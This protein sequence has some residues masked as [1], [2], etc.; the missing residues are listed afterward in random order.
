MAHGP[1][2]RDA[3]RPAAPFVGRQR[4]RAELS[5]ALAGALTGDGSLLLL[6]GES[7]IGKTRLAREV[8]DEA[9]ARGA[10]VLWGAAWDAGGAPAFWP[11]MQAIR[12]LLVATDED[13]LRS[14]L[15]PGAAYV[16]QIVGDVRERVPGLAPAPALDSD[17]ARFTAFDATATF[18]RAAAARRP[19]LVVLDDLH[20]AD[21]PSVVLL[22]FLAR[23]LH[24]A[25]ILLLGTY[26]EREA[27]GEVGEALAA[28]RPAGRTLALRGLE[29]DDVAVLVAAQAEGPA[30]DRL[31]RRVHA[32]TEGN[33]LFVDEVTRLLAAEGGLEA[34]S[35]R[36][37]LP[38]GVRDTI[39]RRL[40]PL[41]APARASLT[42]AAV[43][44]TQFGLETLV[45]AAGAD[46]AGVLGHLD[47]ALAAGLVED[48][49]VGSY[50]FT[51]ALVRETLYDDLSA[52]RRIELHGAVGAALA[53][54]HGDRADAALS[55]LAH[56]FLQAAPGGGAERAVDYAGRAGDA[57]MEVLAY[58]RAAEHYRGALAATHLLA[59][60]PALRASLHERLGEALMRAG[61]LAGGREALGEA[62][63][64]AR[65]TGDSELL[66]RAAL[67]TAAWGLSTGLVDEQHLAPLLEQALARLGPGDSALRARVQSR[68]AAALYWSDDPAF[69]AT[70][71]DEAIAMARRVGDP[72]TLA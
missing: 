16:A 26:R 18:L 55:G 60:D 8:A 22:G 42:L 25:R 37:P 52:R 9:A 59:P 11:W 5:G 53:E 69:R 68:L 19:L 54:L 34:G 24:G 2:P 27:V 14:D 33:P 51:H 57:A 35:G 15:G 46:R 63:T 64:I 20:A 7:G 45:H 3:P 36:I 62:A 41:S 21:V 43:I 72:A 6:T 67:G 47:E 49:G 58:E 39:R 4:E 28:A 10:A 38:D 70:L 23:G 17:A 29:P 13:D 32:L 65:R 12:E 44:G 1:P 61:D 56:H 30:P 40:A 31:V 50:R 71:A 66:A 48:D